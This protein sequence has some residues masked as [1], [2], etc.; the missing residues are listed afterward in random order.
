MFFAYFANSLSDN[1][2]PITS[3]NEAKRT[4]SIIGTLGF[5]YVRSMFLEEYGPT[6]VVSPFV[7]FTS[8]SILTSP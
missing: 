7:F 2:L 5:V 4:R 3:F 1:I 8:I 6:L